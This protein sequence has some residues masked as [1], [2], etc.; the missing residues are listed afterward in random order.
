MSRLCPLAVINFSCFCHV[1]GSV[2]LFSGKHLLKCRGLWN[3]FL[4]NLVGRL[5][6]TLNGPLQAYSRLLEQHLEAYRI[7]ERAI[8]P[9]L[10][11]V[12]GSY[13]ELS[14]LLCFVPGTRISGLPSDVALP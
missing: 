2:L 10:L 5:P 11:L 6:A 14:S 3:P 1:H 9:E 7:W 8:Y 12:K 13:L 4:S